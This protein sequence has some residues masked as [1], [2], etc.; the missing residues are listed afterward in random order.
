MH[1]SILAVRE[2]IEK[3]LANVFGSFELTLP[4]IAN[5]KLCNEKTLLDYELVP[6]ALLHFQWDSDVFVKFLK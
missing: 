6:S 1:E 5:K 3:N 2:F 4:Y